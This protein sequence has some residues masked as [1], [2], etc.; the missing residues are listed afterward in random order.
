MVIFYMYIFLRFKRLMFRE[1]FLVRRRVYIY[2]HLCTTGNFKRVPVSRMQTNRYHLPCQYSFQDHFIYDLTVLFV[3]TQRASA[4]RFAE[5]IS[6]QR[7]EFKS[8]LFRF[9]SLRISSLVY[10]I[11]IEKQSRKSGISIHDNCS[12]PIF[13]SI[14]LHCFGEVMTAKG[15]N[16]VECKNP[17]W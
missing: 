11:K 9:L 6:A 12:F 3:H 16:L 2:A 17:C 15:Q 8:T 4:R 1:I 10:K 5:S 14:V 13:F 7:T